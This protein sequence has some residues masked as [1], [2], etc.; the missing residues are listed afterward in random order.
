M[1]HLY[2][3]NKTGALL[4][5]DNYFNAWVDESVLETEF[6][7]L[8]VHEIEHGE[9]ISRNNIV[10]PVIGSISPDMLSGGT[11]ALLS[12]YYS[13]KLLM[14]LASMGDNCFSLLDRLSKM[15]D[16][17]ICTDSYRELYENGFRGQIYLEDY[18]KTVSSKSE[19]YQEWCDYF[20]RNL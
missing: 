10:L 14:D 18:N 1:L 16:I 5:G 9:V 7:R 15:K 20:E 13:D 8:V 11:K 19:L 3:G 12:L 17:F 2:F 4:S 6:G